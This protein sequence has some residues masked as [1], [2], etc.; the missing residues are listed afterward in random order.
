MAAAQPRC[1][2][3][4]AQVLLCSVLMR[5]SVLGNLPKKFS[6]GT[7]AESWFT[8]RSADSCPS[9]GTNRL[10]ARES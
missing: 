3:A 9:A 10:E 7:A 4:V 6:G 5:R 1:V 2:N 8:G